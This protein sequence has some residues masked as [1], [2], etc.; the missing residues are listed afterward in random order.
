MR[1]QLPHEYFNLI[2]PV[3]K[4]EQRELPGMLCCGEEECEKRAREKICFKR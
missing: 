4:P 1:T 3:L 2:L